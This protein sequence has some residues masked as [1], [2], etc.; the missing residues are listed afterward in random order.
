MWFDLWPSAAQYQSTDNGSEVDPGLP[1]FKSQPAHP[2][3]VKSASGPA[4]VI[5]SCLAHDG[6]PGKSRIL[7]APNRGG[8]LRRP[9]LKI[10]RL[11]RL[12]NL[13]SHE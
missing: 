5:K 4:R 3:A 7:H 10:N 13:L 8:F 6:I 1:A 9:M 11:I 2:L 12:R